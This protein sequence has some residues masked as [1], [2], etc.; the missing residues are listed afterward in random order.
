MVLYSHFVLRLNNQRFL[1][2]LTFFDIN[3]ISENLVFLNIFL[4]KFWD[5]QRY[6]L[7]YLWAPQNILTGKQYTGQQGMSK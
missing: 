7:G 3:F 5:F 4:E 6:T 2:Y 1:Y